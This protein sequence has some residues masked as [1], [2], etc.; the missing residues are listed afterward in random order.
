MKGNTL[1]VDSFHNGT[2]GEY[3]AKTGAT[4]N[5][6]FITGLPLSG[7]QVLALLGNRL[8]VADSFSGAVG[9]YDATSGEAINASFITGLGFPIGIAIRSAK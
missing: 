8:F 9:E 7:P 4:I 2:V 6:N 3:D 5:A 1:F